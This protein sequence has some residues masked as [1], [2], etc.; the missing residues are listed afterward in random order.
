MISTLLLIL[1][2]CNLEQEENAS[3]PITSI[4]SGIITSNNP[5]H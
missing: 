4:L 3:S 5:V 2:Y 1:T